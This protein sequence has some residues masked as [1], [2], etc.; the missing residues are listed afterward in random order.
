MKMLV[1]LSI[2]HCGI[3]VEDADHPGDWFGLGLVQLG[4]G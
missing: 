4:D 1:R 2:V 3:A